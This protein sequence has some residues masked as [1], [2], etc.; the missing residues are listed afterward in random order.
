MEEVRPRALTK[1]KTMRRNL[2]CLAIFG[3]GLGCSDG[4]SGGASVPLADLP[5][6]LADVLCT[7]Y[8][9]CFGPLFAW[10]TNGSD[11]VTITEQ[12]VRNG[13][14]AL[15]QREIDAGKASYDPSKVQACL[16]SLRARTCAQLLERDS[17]ACLAALDG[18]VELGGDCTLDEDCKGK[19]IC[20]SVSGTC[21]GQCA[22]LL[23]AGQACTQ[24][25]DCQDGLQCSSETKLCVQPVGEGQSCEN[26]APPCG[27]GLL[28][29]GKDDS[30]KTPGTCKL[31]SAAFASASGSACDP[32]AGQL[33]QLDS[34]CVAES[35]SLA[36][37][38]I[39]WVCMPNGTYAAGADCKPGFPDACA[40]GTYCK[41]G[42]G[43]AALSGTCT[44][45][46]PVGQPCASGIYSCQSGAVC[47]AGTCQNYAANGVSCTGDAMCYS[48][49]CGP[50]KGCEARLPCK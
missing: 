49:Y 29:L 7:T 16:D 37:V 30:K 50:S 47:A 38:S 32:T 36:T 18:K 24:D 43:L 8:E 23:A 28:C 1:G 3:L 41:T 33:C 44:S 45:L 40:S 20:R 15:L 42:T 12:R 39:S 17:E 19:A 34:A 9:N 10:F 6:K 5:P 48:G 11:C 21:P 2:A 35:V 26:G 14:F 4:S 13:T 46:P 22:P 31:P 27:P 25:S